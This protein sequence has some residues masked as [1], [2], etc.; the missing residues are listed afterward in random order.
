MNTTQVALA[1][2]IALASDG[3]VLCFDQDGKQIEL[4]G[5]E[6]P[7]EQL[8]AMVNEKKLLHYQP[9]S[10]FSMQGSECRIVIDL[11]FAVYCFKYDCITGQYLGRC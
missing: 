7:R 9:I 11:G 4:E 3:E 10:L 2:R 5:K 1:P 8:I 6:I